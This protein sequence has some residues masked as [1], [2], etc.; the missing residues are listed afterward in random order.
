MQFSLITTPV[1]VEFHVVPKLNHLE[2]FGIS[3]FAK[4]NPQTDWYKH[5]VSLDLDTE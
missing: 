5:S 1:A 4:Y 3:S 2:I